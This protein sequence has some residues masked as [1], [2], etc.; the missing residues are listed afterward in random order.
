MK[1]NECG[2]CND[3]TCSECA[4][5]SVKSNGVTINADLYAAEFLLYAFHFEGDAAPKRSNTGSRAVPLMMLA[6]EG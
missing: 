1:K 3:W 5:P 4:R 2:Q 6:C